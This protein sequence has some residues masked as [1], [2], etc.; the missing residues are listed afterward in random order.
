MYHKN[1]VIILLLSFLLST[2]FTPIKLYG[3]DNIDG[4]LLLYNKQWVAFGNDQA[5]RLASNGEKIYLF[6]PTKQFFFTNNDF[7]D[8]EQNRNVYVVARINSAGQYA[9]YDT[10]YYVKLSPLQYDD[11][12]SQNPRIMMLKDAII[13]MNKSGCLSEKIEE[14]KINNI[15]D[16]EYY[17]SQNN[18]YNLSNIQI[19]NNIFKE[20]EKHPEPKR[21]YFNVIYFPPGIYDF[22]ES[23]SIP[24]SNI[25][26]KGA[27]TQ[28]DKNG[29]RSIIRFNYNKMIVGDNITIYGKSLV[30]IEDI[31]IESFNHTNSRLDGAFHINISN[32]E[33]VWVRNIYSYNP[34]SS[35]IEISNSKYIEI[36]DSYFNECISA[37][38]GGNGYGVSLGNDAK[39]CLI[40]NN[41]FTHLRHSIIL[42]NKPKYNVIGY[43]YSVYRKNDENGGIFLLADLCFH[44]H[45]NSNASGVSGPAFNLV[46]G[47]IAQFLNFDVW[48]GGSDYGNIILNN[49][50][51]NDIRIQHTS[52]S[53]H[54]YSDNSKDQVIH[55]NY[56]DDWGIWDSQV[57]DARNNK[58]K[59]GNSY[60]WE[61]SKDN[62]FN[63]KTIYYKN[64]SKPSFMNDFPWPFISWDHNINN[65]KRRYKNNN[66][67]KV[68]YLGFEDYLFENLI[69]KSNDLEGNFTVKGSLTIEDSTIKAGKSLNIKSDEKIILKS[70][71]KAESNSNLN[72]KIE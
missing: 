53:P 10:P 7:N 60:E 52:T 57:T 19:L 35:H 61:K 23:I 69:I 44:G 58:V 46:E 6:S 30:G 21:N 40:E 24:S 13:E 17:K 12:L 62:Q 48:W 26:L 66:F 5:F 16:F 8:F 56:C 3:D 20:I 37:S 67:S 42:G 22:N 33:K 51:T 49:R 64:R 38:D 31:E 70:G 1:R 9:E 18:K 50:I 11:F 71:F 72:A 4:G 14:K 55:Q 34:I 54:E 47:N 45:E 29:N 27:G 25:I 65:A 39:Y 68:K 59:I 28:F 2:V 32:C 15:F 43:N 63:L 41:I 36:R